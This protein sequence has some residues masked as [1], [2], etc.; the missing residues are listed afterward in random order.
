MVG[1]FGRKTGLLVSLTQMPTR[2]NILPRERIHTDGVFGEF[3]KY[4]PETKV[5]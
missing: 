3:Q 2:T 4:I 5:I 1:L